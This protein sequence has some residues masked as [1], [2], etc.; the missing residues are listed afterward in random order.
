[1]EIHIQKSHP[2]P[3]LAQEEGQIA[4]H[5]AFSH[6]PF[7]AHHQQL[8]AHATQIG[9]NHLILLRPLKVPGRLTSTVIHLHRS[10]PSSCGFTGSP[11]KV[12]HR[13]TIIDALTG[14]VFRSAHRGLIAGPSV[15]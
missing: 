9:L 13:H 10:F 6:A 2:I 1:M 5:R 11:F 12:N 14:I 15:R 4:R 7:A 3:G 8:P